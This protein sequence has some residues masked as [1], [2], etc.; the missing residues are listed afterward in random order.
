MADK[1][2]EPVK[3]YGGLEPRVTLRY[4]INDETSLKAAVTR[5]LQY[6][7]LVTNAGTTLPTDLWV[8]S[9]YLVQPQI[10]WLYALGFFKNF[11]DNTYET[12]LEV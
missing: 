5:N 6:I 4:A 11:T 12:S 2:F 1:S 9:T 3:T 8:P 7:H 10:S